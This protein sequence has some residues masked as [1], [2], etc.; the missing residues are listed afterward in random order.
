MSVFGRDALPPVQV[1]GLHKVRARS[2]PRV[3]DRIQEKSGTNDKHVE[4]RGVQQR[5]SL[6]TTLRTLRSRATHH[7]TTLW[8]NP[9]ANHFRRDTHTAIPRRRVR[10]ARRRAARDVLDVARIHGAERR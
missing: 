1:H 7:R 9:Q 8:R 3:V 2:V 5:V 10:V 6:Q 4:V